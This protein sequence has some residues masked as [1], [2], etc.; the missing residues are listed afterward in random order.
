MVEKNHANDLGW[1]K[2]GEIMNIKVNRWIMSGIFYVMFHPL[3]T[4]S[5]SLVQR[6]IFLYHYGQK[7]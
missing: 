3:I 5:Q 1:Q 4:Q 6:G 7:I 2:V